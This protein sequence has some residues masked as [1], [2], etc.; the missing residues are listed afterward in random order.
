MPPLD[1]G[2]RRFFGHFKTHRGWALVIAL[3]NLLGIAY[4]FYYYRPQFAATPLWL[5]P[6][7]PDSPLAVLWAQLALIAYW[8]RRPPGALD[9]LAV[10][11]NVQ[12][13]LWTVYVL[14]AYA[15]E[16][17]TYTLNLNTILLAAH[18]AMALLAL[19]FVQGLRERR[20]TSPRAAGLALGVAAAY[21]LV[22]DAL[23][24]FG[25]DHLG[26]G[27][28]LRPYTVPCDPVREPILVAVT[29]G[30]TLVGVLVV[31]WGMRPDRKPTLDERGYPPPS[32]P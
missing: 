20:T 5:W 17:G 8:L 25:P 3:V 32:R 24:Y 27:C 21:Y 10:V 31:A 23:D 30:L 14:V 6:F 2:P 1:A 26:S 12:V 19:I 11:G 13:G 22:N 15:P 7:V 16:F 18:A 28:G 9:A 29:V 4:G